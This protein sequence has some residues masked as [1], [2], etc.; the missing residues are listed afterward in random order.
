MH[1]ST[2][3]D[4]RVMLGLASYDEDQPQEKDEPPTWHAIHEFDEN[5]DM[6]VFG[7]TIDTEW[8]KKIFSGSIKQEY[9][10]YKH[11]KN[12]GDGEFFH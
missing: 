9:N 12:Y 5:F 11:V 2:N 6:N 10:M 4:T 7:K 8:T 3:A 1:H